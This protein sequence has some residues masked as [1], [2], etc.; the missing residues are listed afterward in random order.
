MNIYES[1]YNLLEEFVFGGEIVAQSVQDLTATLLSTCGT[2]FVV[3]LP[4]IV[5]FFALKLI[6][7]GR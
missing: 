2:I 6:C 7:G 1:L 4:F 5:V 3:A